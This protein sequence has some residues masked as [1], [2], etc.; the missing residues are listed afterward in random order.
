MEIYNFIA[1]C[2]YNMV[3][4]GISIVEDLGKII[5]KKGQTIVGSITNWERR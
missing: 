3:E 1:A 2:I 4:T 5:D